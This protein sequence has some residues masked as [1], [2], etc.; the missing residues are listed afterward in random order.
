MNVASTTSSTSSTPSSGNRITG[1]SGIDVDSLVKAA[2]LGQQSKID[3]ANQQKQMLQFQQN[4]YRD[5][6]KELR[7]FYSKYMDLAK[8]DN[9][10]LVSKNYQTAVFTPSNGSGAVSAV[11][12]SG[13]QVGNYKVQV[14]A[15][16][17]PARIKF[18]DFNSL[19]GTKKDININGKVVTVDLTSA[20]VSTSKD[21]IMSIFNAAIIKAGADAKMTKSDITGEYILQT[22]GVGSNDTIGYNP[23]K[24]TVALSDLVG[25]NVSFEFQNN[26]QTQTVSV[27]L[28]QMPNTNATE[29]DAILLKLKNALGSKAGFSI[30]ASDNITFS[31]TALGTGSGMTINAGANTVGPIMGTVDALNAIGGDAKVEITDTYGNTATKT[32]QSNSFTVDNVKFTIS[33]VTSSPVTI[34]GKTD[35]TDLKKRIMDF[36]DDY[37]K[38]IGDITSR[39]T[40]KKNRD[41]PPLTDTQRASMT[42]DQITQWEAKT[43]EGMLR[44]DNY[45]SG[46]VS[47]LRSAFNT[48][49]TGQKLKYYD[50]GFDFSDDVTTPGQLT[51]DEGKLTA[52][53]ENSPDD[54]YKLFTNMAD[55]AL[56]KDQQ[57]KDNGI[58]QRLKN[59]LNDN[60]ISSDSLLLKKVGYTG[61]VTFYNNDLL[62]AI[63]TQTKLITDLQDKF[64]DQQNRLYQRYAS[65][66][67]A[68]NNYNSQATYLAN[69]FGGGQ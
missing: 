21:T 57:F 38:M 45:L 31:T 61:S 26:G 34:Q 40:E 27:D 55:S 64:V 37:N 1:L 23:A 58:M 24:A 13:A 12:L 65:L 67:T 17:T 3:K 43:K 18:T 6:I 9:S 63:D 66:E 33:D 60:V 2:M 25:Q 56:S 62:K 16:A 8:P 10:M 41:Y 15:L 30:D 20:D 68:M 36:V 19:V 52:S 59:I 49:V 48:P 14:D 35:I 28:T 44:N 53:L 32:Y 4:A 5:V 47:S 11:G 50:I 39:L 51:V 22:N 69:A 7:D 42:T 29:K 46:I 54:V